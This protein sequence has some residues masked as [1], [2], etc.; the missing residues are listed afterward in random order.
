[1]AEHSPPI[2]PAP[3][4]LLGGGGPG[5]FRLSPFELITLGGI[6]LISAFIGYNAYARFTDLNATPPPAPTYLPAFRTTLT[7][8]VSSTGSV[9]STQQVSLNFDIGQGTGKIQQ[10]FVRLG[11]RVTAGQPMAKLDDTDLQKTLT[12]ARSNLA[13]ATARLNAVTSPTTA[14][15]SAAQQ[16]VAA[17]QNQVLTASNNLNKLKN[18]TPADLAASQQAVTSANQGLITAQNN[19][20]TAQNAITT[21]QAN[22]NT[23]QNDLTTAQIALQSAYLSLQNS[24]SAVQ[25]SGCQSLIPGVPVMGSVAPTAYVPPTVFGNIAPTPGPVP[26]G[27]PQA[28]T[29]NSLNCGSSVNSYNG[30]ASSYNTALATHVS[31][32]TALQKAQNDL[33]NG[34][35]QN[36]VTQATAGVATAQSNIQAAQTKLDAL[37]RPQQSDIDAAQASLN[38]AQASLT[39]AQARQDALF[40]PT[41]DQVL[42]LQAQ[43]DQAQAQVA[44]AEKNFQNATIVA[45][46][47]GQVSQVTGDVGTLVTANTAV[48]IL[49]NQARLRIDANVDQ[50]DVSGLRAGQVATVTF[51]ALPGRTFQ[52]SIV[53]IGLTPQVQQGVV[54]YVVQL[55][56]DTSTLQ[57]PL[58]APG[59]TA[60]INVVTQRIDSAL[61]VPTRSVRRAAGRAS[62]TLKKDDGSTE[63]RQV[64]TGATS[65]QLTQ[66]L[67]GL[68]EGDQVLV[69]GTATARTTAALPGGIQ[70]PAPGR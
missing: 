57:P 16:A 49:L 34:N 27:S 53:A 59:M 33:N 25:A 29:L 44:T 3:R 60:L 23:A 35:L 15:V 48:F 10:F 47:D 18:P 66:I 61:V 63:V 43:V 30:S 41:P 24:F 5:R 51:D 36:N 11:D 58:P 14:D 20:Q 45:P 4:V 2:G 13:S 39:A 52:A 32:T 40:K 67:S 19:V 69:S 7:S 62:V 65:G 46:F 12:S 64:T 26:F 55:S 54:T 31:R 8:S 68:Q 1:V 42:P 28:N 70:A 22:V 56:L 17:A 21:A 38:S 9:A 6:I 50:A 37:L